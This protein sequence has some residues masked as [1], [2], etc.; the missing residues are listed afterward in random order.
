[1]TTC[2]HGSWGMYSG[3]EGPCPP[4]TELREIK[5]GVECPTCGYHSRQLSPESFAQMREVATAQRE[6]R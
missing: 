4:P 1:M 2:T 6:T 3:E 5:G